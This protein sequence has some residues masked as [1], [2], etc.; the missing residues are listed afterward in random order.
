M[1]S[2]AV[3]CCVQGAS[4]SAK[5]SREKA[6]TAVLEEADIVCSTLAFAG[7]GLLER[8]ARPFDGVVIDEAAQAV[9]PS[10][11]IPLVLGCQQV[12][13]SQAATSLFNT[14]FMH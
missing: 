6:R 2:C 10:T 5:A 13:H 9:E 14:R 11:L 12:W 1:C 8:L 3:V 7:S 4:A